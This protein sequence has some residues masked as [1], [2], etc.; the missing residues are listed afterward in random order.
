M[1]YLNEI[2]LTIEKKSTIPQKAG[3]TA[4]YLGF[5]LYDVWNDKQIVADMK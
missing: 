1:I 5:A 3:S 4:K 2:N